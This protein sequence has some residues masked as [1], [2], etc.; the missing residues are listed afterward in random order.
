M[1]SSPGAIRPAVSTLRRG[2]LS[3]L[4]GTTP[5]RT[6]GSINLR[7]IGPGNEK[8]DPK[9]RLSP[10]RVKSTSLQY[11][12][13]VAV[14]L[15]VSLANFALNPLVGVHATALIFLLMVVILSLFVERGPVLLA[16]ALSALVWDYFFLPPVFAFR[17]S[18]VED[19]ML[20]GMYF[21]LAIILGQLT[22]QLPDGPGSGGRVGT[23]WQNPA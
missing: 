3:I 11:S 20:L 9:L 23:P 21:V 19:A 10:R 8:L 2:K 14:V 22:A 4:F 13:V 1:D 15:A 7:S 6:K 12:A 16:A 17:V 18:H 5:R